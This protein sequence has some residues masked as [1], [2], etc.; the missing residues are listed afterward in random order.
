MDRNAVLRLGAL[1][2]IL[3][4]LT[5][6]GW[7]TMINMPG[8]S[9]NGPLPPLTE[10]MR[11][12]EQELRGHVYVLANAIGERNLVRYE[13][14][15]EAASYL[16][17]TLSTY[18]YDVGVQSYEVG[19]NPCENLEVEIVGRDTPKEIVLIGAHYD[20]VIGTPGAN[21][22]A[23][24]VAALLALARA[25]SKTQPS[26][27]LRFVA[28]VNEEPPYFQTSSMG[29]WVYAKRSRERD[30][31]IVAM[32]SLETIGYYSDEP[33]S[34]SY[35]PPFSLFYPSTGN[36]IAFVGNTQNGRLVR[37]A[38]DV[39]RRHAQF[40]SEGGAL[41]GFLPGVGWSDHWSFWK[42]DYP[43]IMVTDTALFRY[44]SYHLASDTPEKVRYDRLAR[45]VSGLR[46]VIGELAGLAEPRLIR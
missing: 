6:V 7:F 34:Q 37:H 44:P 32:V 2:A 13:G 46:Q 27:T 23:T 12:L 14:L 35:P 20:S 29:S 3:G 18:G 26:R 45:V 8:H 42:E 21:D 17:A 25:Y 33:D 22:N 41:F 19:K 5:T 16:R 36:F 39:F 38:V 30:E 1:G 28:F 24:G 4:I 15:V 10:E 43:A 31:N 9:H 40:P 11:G